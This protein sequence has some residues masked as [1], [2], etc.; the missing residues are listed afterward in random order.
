M[1]RS[2]ARR[3]FGS[4]VRF[5]A[6]I[7]RHRDLIV[8]M[9]RRELA[10]RYV[11]STLGFLWTF[12]HPMVMIFVFWMVFSV[13]FKS[14]P[15]QGVPFVVW[16]AAGMAAWF[17]FAD[18][19][20][21]SAGVILAHAALIKKTVFPS[22][23]LPLVKIVSCLITHG[24]FLAILL[25]LMLFQG[26]APS[27]W[28]LQFLYYLACLVTL[29]LGIGWGVSA[30]NVFSRDVA[31]MVAVVLQVGFWATPVFWDIG[32]MPPE[33]QFAIKL[34]PM[35][36]IVQGYRESFLTPLVFWR[37]PLQTAYFW[38]LTTVIFILGASVF[39]RLKQEFPDVI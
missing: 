10:A 19:V 31:Q 3:L 9:A 15:L 16:L 8:A 1:H 33:V 34:N 17:A 38:C 23:I 30:L 2:F 37:H 13:G 5:V 18:I 24:V 20:N 39:K 14:Q 28:N 27:L 35:F 4:T 36:Y 12:I 6:L 29:A 7:L 32:I 21:G 22:Q 26:P 25:V 11:G